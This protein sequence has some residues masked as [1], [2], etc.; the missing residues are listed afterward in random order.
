MFK[1]VSDVIDSNVKVCCGEELIIR[2]KREIDMQ[3]NSLCNL[4]KKKT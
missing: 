2:L 1:L 3:V 4:N